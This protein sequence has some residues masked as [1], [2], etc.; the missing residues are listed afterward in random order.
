MLPSWHDI[1]LSRIALLERMQTSY[2]SA[3]SRGF[4]S[5]DEAYINATRL[6]S[7]E[8]WVD[9]EAYKGTLADRYYAARRWVAS[10]YLQEQL[11]DALLR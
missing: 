7:N 3:L 10:E 9:H 11:I 1:I 6:A 2:E 8:G 5:S 4:W